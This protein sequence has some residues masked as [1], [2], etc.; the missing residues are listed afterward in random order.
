MVGYGAGFRRGESESRVRR[1]THPT[2]LY[3]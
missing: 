3:G 1:L 2:S